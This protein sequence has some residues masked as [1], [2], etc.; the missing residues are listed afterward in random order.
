MRNFIFLYQKL[1]LDY[2]YH[3][4]ELRNLESVPAGVEKKLIEIVAALWGEMIMTDFASFPSRSFTRAFQIL[5]L[6]IVRVAVFA[7]LGLTLAVFP[8]AVFAN[9]TPTTNVT[10]KANGTGCA[11]SSCHGVSADATI[12]VAVTGPTTLTAGS[13]GTYT[14]TATKSGIANST[15][16]GF[17]LRVSDGALSVVAGQSTALT[18]GEITHSA[19][20]G[21]LAT[22]LSNSA[23]Y[24]FKYTMPA[25]AAAGSTHLLYSVSAL[26]FIGWNHGSPYTVTVPTPIPVISSGSTAS[27]TVGLA[28][29]YQIT[30]SNTPTSYGVT[31]TLPTSVTLNTSSGLISG[32][33]GNSGTFNVN[34]TATNGGGTS[35]PQPVTITIAPAVVAATRYVNAATGSNTSN[36]CSVLG[37]PCKTITYAMTQALAGNPG[38][39]ISVAP[40][41]YNLTLGEVFPIVMKS[42]VQLIATGSPSDT[43]IDATGA[44]TRLFNASDSNVSTLIQGFTITGGFNVGPAN[45]T[46][47]GGGA[48]LIDGINQIKIRR[49]IFTGNEA[50]GFGGVAASFSKEGYG[51]AISVAG[52]LATIENNV[53]RANTARG[54]DGV[55]GTPGGAAGSGH[56]GAISGSAAIIVNNTFYA[57]VAQ[58][59]S[60]GSSSGQGGAGGSAFSSAVEMNNTSVVNNIFVNNSTI[61]GT[62]GSGSPPGSAGTAIGGAVTANASPSNTNNLFF[63]NTSNGD[64]GVN[65]VLIDPQ[66]HSAPAILKIKIGSPAT[67][68]GTSTGAPATDFAGVTRP[69][70]PAIGAYE[71]SAPVTAPKSALN[72]I[73][74]FLID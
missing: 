53:F 48:I 58:G 2:L 43:I 71:P 54:G 35:T 9:S 14:I 61:G 55:T 3:K 56:G 51:G 46:N 59:G 37:S 70:P 65:F 22:T 40:G 21:A 67:G 29:N 7:A 28:F 18:S 34:V 66:F 13:I 69:S 16:M 23:S 47:I 44:N 30:A 8:H 41:T 19:I 24:S 62:G 5:H 20:V 17:D 49:N 63:G 45:G 38:D 64:T 36:T 73:L 52:G 33:P 10:G 39:L 11:G 26:G 1:G 60:G 32:T 27:G 6:G 25:N 31:G 4:G 72:P 42:G 57:N 50:R 74:F 15:K 12:G 68:A